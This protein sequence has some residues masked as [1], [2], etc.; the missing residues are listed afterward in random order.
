MKEV[1]DERAQEK[2]VRKFEKGI[3]KIEADVNFS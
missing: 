1:V 3:L 2:R